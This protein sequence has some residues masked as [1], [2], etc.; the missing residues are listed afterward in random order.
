MSEKTLSFVKEDLRHI[1]SSLWHQAGVMILISDCRGNL[2]AINNIAKTKLGYEQLD[3]GKQLRTE[4][5][6][7][8]QDQHA[9]LY[10]YYGRSPKGDFS[11]VL[12]ARLSKEKTVHVEWS[13]VTKQQEPLPVLLSVSPLMN[14]LHKWVGYVFIAFDITERKNQEKLMQASLA[15][16]KKLGSLKSRFVTI[17][18]HEFRTPLSTI[19]S[20][21]HLTAKYTK[22]ADQHKRE[23]HL[24]R[25]ISA[26]H[27]LTDILN[28]FLNVGKIEEGK[29][30]IKIGQLALDEFFKT[31]L[32]D[33]R[34]NAKKGQQF[35]YEHTGQTLVYTDQSLVKNILINLISNAIKFSSENAMIRIFSEA[36]DRSLKLTVEDEGIGIEPQDIEHLTK[37]FFRGTNASNIQGTGLG[38]HIVAKYVERLQGKMTC[39]SV[40]G[41]GTKFTIY[42][43]FGDNI[44]S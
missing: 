35:I 39:S 40:P 32:H 34:A 16:E 41:I 17:A 7:S 30:S 27:T 23:R 43:P 31:V 42:L 24:N 18:S 11:D 3:F 20:S 6:I 19:A 29:I 44:G 13:F 1:Y 26:V 14:S 9:F 15:K 12:Q 10:Q 21:A 22:E 8:T 38:L 37:R 33:I 25:I 36:D 5:I 28:E 2:Q 4:D